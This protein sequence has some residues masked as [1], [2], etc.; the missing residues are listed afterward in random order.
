M[1]EMFEKT[2]GFWSFKLE[3]WT[4]VVKISEEMSANWTLLV[5]IKKKQQLTGHFWCKF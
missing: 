4:F 5:E 1:V 3:I 2:A